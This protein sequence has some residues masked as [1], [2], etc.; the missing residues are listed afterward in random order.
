MMIKEDW[1]NLVN[2]CINFFWDTKRDAKMYWPI[3]YR[4]SDQPECFFGSMILHLGSTSR[5]WFQACW[6]TCPWF[7]L[8][9]LPAIV[10][11]VAPLKNARSYCSFQCT[12]LVRCDP[13]LIHS[14]ACPLA[15]SQCTIKDSAAAWLGRAVY[16]FLGFF[17]GMVGMFVDPESM[18]FL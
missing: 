9:P 5:R 3:C 18:T 12:P 8:H 6:T 1:N 2:F 14:F 15:V 17:R 10:G 4:S 11:Y 16:S 13:V 7:S